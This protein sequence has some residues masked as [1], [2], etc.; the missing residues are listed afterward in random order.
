MFVLRLLIS[1]E[2]SK[3]ILFGIINKLGGSNNHRG[4]GVWKKI[5][6]LK[7]PSWWEISFQNLNI[8]HI[9]AVVMVT[10]TPGHQLLEMTTFLTSKKK[11]TSTMKMRLLYYTAM[12]RNLVLLGMFSFCYLCST[13][14]S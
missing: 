13:K 12:V 1:V 2:V 14:N 11:I 6:V 8:T 9:F 4:M 5:M 3:K 10:W 7:F